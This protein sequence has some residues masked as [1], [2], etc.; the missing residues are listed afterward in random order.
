[1]DHPAEKLGGTLTIRDVPQLIVEA[2]RVRWDYDTYVWA[3]KPET[4]EEVMSQIE[5]E[6]REGGASVISLVFL[7]VVL[8]RLTKTR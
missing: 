5:L 1:M 3:R 4:Y 6:D 2:D 8:Y 7:C